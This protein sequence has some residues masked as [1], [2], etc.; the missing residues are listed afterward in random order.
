MLEWRFEPGGRW[1]NPHA[2]DLEQ[3]VIVLC[4]QG[5]SSVFAAGM[6]AQLGYSRAGDVVGGFEGW[7][8]AG[9]PIVAAPEPPVGRPGMGDPA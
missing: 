2:G 5:Y 1:R 4:E 8:E 6:L 7:R 9:L 3:R